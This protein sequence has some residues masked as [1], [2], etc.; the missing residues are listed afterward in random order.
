[1]FAQNAKNINLRI[2]FG[3]FGIAVIPTRYGGM[4]GDRIKAKKQIGSA[5]RGKK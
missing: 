4:K 1:V 2:I 5:E 3:W